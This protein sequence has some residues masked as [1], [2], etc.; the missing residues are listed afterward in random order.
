MNSL[1]R[2]GLQR[3]IMLLVTLGLAGMFTVGG[4]LGLSAI[5]QASALVFDERLATA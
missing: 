3:R 5:D 1:R 2:P 4:F